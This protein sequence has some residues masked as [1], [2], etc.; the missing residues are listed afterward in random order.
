MKEKNIASKKNLSKKNGSI[1]KAESIIRTIGKEIPEAES[2]V[3]TLGKESP[4]MGSDNCVW[5]IGNDI[6]ESA[7]E[8]WKAFELGGETDPEDQ[9]EIY[10][11]KNFADNG[12]NPN[13]KDE[14]ID[15]MAGLQEEEESFAFEDILNQ[16]SKSKGDDFDDTKYYFNQLCQKPLL[17]REEEYAIGC[18]IR[19][20]RLAKERWEE[21]RVKMR[22][23][24]CRKKEL[25]VLSEL[26]KTVAEGK[27]AEKELVGSNYRLVMHEI[28][29]IYSHL[30]TPMDKF[31]EGV[32]GLMK[33]AEKF[34][35]DKG[36]RFST[37]ACWWI[38]QSIYRALEE[39]EKA[40]RMPSQV[41]NQ[42]DK[43]RKVINKLEVEQKLE[44]SKMNYNPQQ[45]ALI[46]SRMEISIE[47]VKELL[48]LPTN[49]TYL[50]TPIAGEGKLVLG[51]IVEA[52]GIYNQESFV[53]ENTAK[54]LVK[55]VFTHL[56]GKEKE[57]MCLR[58]GIGSREHTLEEIGKIYGIS[59][60]RVR[61]IIEQARRKII[62]IPSLSGAIRHF[63]AD[64]A[65]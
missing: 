21:L 59:R 29:K 64:S 50:E 32:L 53:Q 9:I 61:Q 8:L 39:K 33:A 40:I 43:L 48:Q 25:A 31:Q 10:N 46:A 45:L 12:I 62:R 16:D 38:R 35:V 34:D 56:T 20:G 1:Q 47:K 42:M 14:D 41:F 11:E 51:D 54:N 17:S 23:G 37:Y 58:Y 5:E 49:I 4:K 65:S 26:E 3:Q 36:F 44:R 2:D 13:I 7:E 18:R 6:S 63:N 60:E 15:S 52:T 28:K 30:L 27:K 55:D 22:E 19:D 24:K 57:V